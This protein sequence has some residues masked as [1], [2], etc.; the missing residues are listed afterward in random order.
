MNKMLYQVVMG[1][2]LLA[3]FA[4]SIDAQIFADALDSALEQHEAIKV[5]TSKEVIYRIA[6]VA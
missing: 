2:D 4:S 3:K 6:E 5:E 1:S